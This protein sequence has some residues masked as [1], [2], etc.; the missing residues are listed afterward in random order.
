MLYF[1]FLL[2][3][4]PWTPSAHYSTHLNEEPQAPTFKKGAAFLFKHQAVTSESESKVRVFTH[5]PKLPHVN[6]TELEQ[7]LPSA[8]VKAEVIGSVYH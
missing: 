4:P 6:L 2:D 8:R 7:M 1:I 5:F 3:I